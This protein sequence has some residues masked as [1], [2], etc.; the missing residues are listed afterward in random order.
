[1]LERG[2]VHVTDVV[3]ALRVSYLASGMYVMG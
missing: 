3:V 2:A 1:M